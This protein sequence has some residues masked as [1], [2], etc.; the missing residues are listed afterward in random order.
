MKRIIAII[1]ALFSL[2][3]ML[4]ACQQLAESVQPPKVFFCTADS[5]EREL[6]S[7]IMNA[8]NVRCT[9]Y[10]L[11]SPT[12][13][14]ALN[15]KNAMVML[16]KQNRNKLNNQLFNKVYDSSRY[17]MH[18]KFC[19]FDENAV[20]TGSWNPTK[21]LNHDNVIVVYSK[22]LAQNYIKKFDELLENKQDTVLH[23]QL[24]INNNLVE[25]YFCPEDKCSEMVKAALAKAE[26]SIRFMQFSFTDDNIGTLLLEKARAGIKVEGIIE[27]SQRSKWDEYNKLQNFSL[28]HS[29]REILHHKVFIIDN[30]T[31]ATGSYNP[32]KNADLHNNENLLIVHDERIAR[33]YNNEFEKIKGEVLAV[34]SQ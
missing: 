9:L 31:V 16:E 28:L 22:Y 10:D 13:V 18:N 30:K 15:Q 32:T 2:P 34:G 8:T 33:L 5:C 12:I 26:F 19:I 27:K 23:P 1:L 6:I 11:D 21:S 3:L 17:L 7:M 24:K 4:S 14:N 20:W 25:N 29:G